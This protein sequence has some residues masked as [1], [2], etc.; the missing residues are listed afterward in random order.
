LKVD[1]E[2]IYVIDTL[3][4]RVWV[5]GKRAFILNFDECTK[6]YDVLQQTMKGL[7]HENLVV[8]GKDSFKEYIT[9]F[10]VVVPLAKVEERLA[11]GN[12]LDLEIIEKVSVEF[13]RTYCTLSSPAQPTK[14]ER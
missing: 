8:I 10:L 2:T 7:P 14:R 3:G 9:S 1:H 5:R 4:D 12:E 11:N 13:S 6:I